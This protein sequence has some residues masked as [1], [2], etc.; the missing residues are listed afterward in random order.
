MCQMA[1]ISLRS[2]ACIFHLI[3][4]RCFT[5][6]PR[7]GKGVFVTYV[8]S[9]VWMSVIAVVFFGDKGNH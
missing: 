2:V 6:F 3:K 8:V 1:L 9:T 7:D 4:T 5:L